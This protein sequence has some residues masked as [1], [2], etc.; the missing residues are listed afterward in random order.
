MRTQQNNPNEADR[1]EIRT[2]G[3]KIKKAFPN[4][5]I[6]IVFCASNQYF[7]Y[8]GVALQSIIDHSSTEYNYDIL[9]MEY[10]V[11]AEN[12][13]QM[14]TMI[15][16]RKN[17]SVRLIDM[18]GKRQEVSI[19]T[20]SHFSIVACFKLF[21]MSEDFS[22]YDKIL[23]LDTDLVFLK[24]AAELYRTDLNGYLMAAVDDV[25]MKS[26]V[27]NNYESL[28]FAPKMPLRQYVEDY[29]GVGPSLHYYNTGVAV[30][31]LAEM[32]KQD[33]FCQGVEKLNTKGYVFQEQDVLNELCAGKILDLDLKWN[34]VGLEQ[35]SYILK[36]LKHDPIL[37]RYNAGL[38]HPAV[39]HFAGDCKPWTYSTM[40]CGSIFFQYAD[41]T[42]WKET[43]AAGVPENAAAQY[44]KL[45]KIKEIKPYVQ[46]IINPFFPVG[47]ERREKLKRVLKR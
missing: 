41:K 2:G 21:L 34:V 4:N 25:I 36:A 23:A 44:R 11:T 10:D 1:L 9:I 29:L 28:G 37:E 8:C 3:E 24:D 40:P 13:A 7:P 12:A 33:M 6:A 5:N 45:K 46:R 38:E 22:E 27:Y 39:L 20:W 42:P 31:N 47:S 26:D 30:L 18:E 14:Y 17:F 16:R 19:K 32:R 15:E 35:Q 43:I